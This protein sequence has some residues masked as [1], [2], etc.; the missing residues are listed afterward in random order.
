MLS[1]ISSNISFCTLSPTNGPH[2]KLS[3]SSMILCSLK[4]IAFLCLIL[5][6][7]H[8]IVSRLI[9]SVFLQCLYS[10]RSSVWVFYIPMFLFNILNTRNTVIITLHILSIL[11]SVNSNIC[12]NSDLGFPLTFGYIFLD[13]CMSDNFLIE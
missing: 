8:F 12:I 1:I 11:I 10:S 3:H 7:F 4:K 5:E 2:L 6:S 13:L 9:R